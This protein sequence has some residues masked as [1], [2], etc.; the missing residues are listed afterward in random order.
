MIA[1]ICSFF[2]LPLLGIAALACAWRVLRGPSL[3]DRVV[4]L[5][6]LSS[7]A[8]AIT[9][10]LCLR[11]EALALLDVGTILALVAFLATLAFARAVETQQ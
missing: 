1:S 10:A 5:E 9:I 8:I 7:V 2:V 11:D 6:I 4:G 3:A